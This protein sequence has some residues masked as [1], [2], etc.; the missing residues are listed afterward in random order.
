MNGFAGWNRYRKWYRENVYTSIKSQPV[1]FGSSA[2]LNPSC[3]VKS[4]QKTHIRKEM[5]QMITV[6]I[7]HW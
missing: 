5:D 3:D 7:G 6:P 1:L 4:K 2:A